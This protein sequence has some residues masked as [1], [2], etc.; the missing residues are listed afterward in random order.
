MNL[1]RQKEWSPYVAG[2]GLG[3]TAAV[4]LSLFGTGSRARAPTSI[5]P[6]IWAASSRAK[7]STGAA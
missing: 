7:A 4:S 1:L 2:A 5:S 3:L 6:V